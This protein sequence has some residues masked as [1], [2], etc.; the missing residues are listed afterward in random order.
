MYIVESYCRIGCRERRKMG[1]FNQENVVQI[2][3]YD[4]LKLR[5]LKKCGDKKMFF[6]SL[7]LKRE[8]IDMTILFKKAKHFTYYR[9]IYFF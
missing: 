1:F 9:R 8:K 3:F 2:Q 4:F 6:F 5:I 7:F